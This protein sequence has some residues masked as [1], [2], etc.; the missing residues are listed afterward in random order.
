MADASVRA[1]SIAGIGTFW[2]LVDNQPIWTLALRAPD[3]GPQ[4]GEAGGAAWAEY[5][6]ACRAPL[7]LALGA[8]D[9]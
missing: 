5:S 8:G 3:G 4:P 9:A 6:R 1:H 2:R 7:C